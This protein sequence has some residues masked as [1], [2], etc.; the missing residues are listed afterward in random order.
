MKSSR[1]NEF[2]ADKF[3]FDLGYGHELCLLLDTFG[4]VE[5]NGVFASL[6]SSHPDIDD[7]IARLQS[8]GVYTQGKNFLSKV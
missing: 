4:D 1:D 8:L 2:E 5:M 6:A 3:A 7:R